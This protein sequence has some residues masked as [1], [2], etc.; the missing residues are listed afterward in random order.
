MVVSNGRVFFS[1][2]FALYAKKTQNPL[3]QNYSYFIFSSKS[4][5]NFGPHSLVQVRVPSAHEILHRYFY[6]FERP[7]LFKLSASVSTGNWSF[8][9]ERSLRLF[10]LQLRKRKKNRP[11][12]VLWSACYFTISSPIQFCCLC[13]GSGEI[14]MK[15]KMWGNRNCLAC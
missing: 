9:P 2:S 10:L 12:V 5:Q 15:G 7:N 6:F 3:I 8:Q 1:Y 13:W 4:K 11:W 14:W